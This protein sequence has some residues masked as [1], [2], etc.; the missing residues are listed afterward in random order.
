MKHFADLVARTLYRCVG[1]LGGG[2]VLL[3]LYVSLGRQLV[4]L[5]AE[6]RADAE[7]IVAR[8]LGVPVSIER[9]EGRWDG[10]LPRLLAH[11][12]FIGEGDNPLRLDRL[13]LVPD[14]AES[15]WTR[16]PYLSELRLAGL[17]LS[18]QQDDTGAWRVE[19]FSPHT[20]QAAADP[21]AILQGLRRVRNL[22]LIDSQLTLT[23]AGGQPQ[24]LSYANLALQSQGER[25]RLDGHLLLPD[26]KPLALQARLDVDGRQWQD[27][28]L[29]L[30]LDLPQSDWAALVPGHLPSDWRVRQLEM[31]GELW[32]RIR[33]RRLERGVARLQA[34][35]LELAQGE[36]SVAPLSE[37][38]VTVHAEQREA[39][40]HMQLDGLTFVQGE[41]HQGD[42]RLLLDQQR[43]TGHWRLRA[44]HVQLR[45]LAHLLREVMVLPEV[46]AEALDDLA[47][48]GLLRNLQLDYRPDRELAQRLSYSANLEAVSIREHGWVPAAGN[49]SGS[50]TGDLGSGE[51]RFDSRDFSL[52]LARLFPAAWH[53]R[54]SQGSLQ[55]H[56]D[57][58]AFT[59]RA[60]YLRLDGEEGQLA[61]DL[62]IRLMRDPEAEDYMD[63]RVGMSD[64]D[65]RFTERY[66][67]T[68]SPALTPA[69]VDWLKDAIRAGHVEQGYF[70]YQGSLNKGAPAVAH[71]LGLY[72]KV[73]DAEL[74]FQPGWP[75][76]REGRGEVLVENGR[77][78]VRLD[79]GRIL[80]SQVLQAQA[81]IAPAREGHT[82]RLALQGKVIGTLADGM[83]ILQEAPLGTGQV[84]AGWQAEG[85]LQAQLDLDI[86]LARG[87]QPQIRVDFSSRDAS[88]QLREP[89]LKLRALAGDF[90]YDS[91]KGLSATRVSAR[92]FG[93]DVSGRILATGRPGEPLSR[94]EVR[95][96]LAL[97]SLTRWLGVT[98]QLPARGEL[99]YQLR[100][101]I[102]GAAARLQ[103]DSSLQG[104]AIDLPEPFR[105]GASTRRDTSFHMTLQGEQRRY[106]FQHAALAAL[107][108]MAPA[109]RLQEGRGELR[110]GGGAA[111]LPGNQGLRVRG[112]LS[113]LDWNAW[114]AVL[115]NVQG[116]G[117]QGMPA[118]LSFLREA[119]L[120]LDRFEGFGT[121]ID[122]L[123]VDLRSI[124][125]AW[126]LGLRSQVVDGQVRL[127]SATGAPIDVRLR[128]LRL[129]AAKEADAQ[130]VSVDPL[131]G[132]DP[133][134]LPA[135]DLLIEQLFRGD[136][137]LGRWA[138]KLRP[139]AGGTAMSDIDLDL[140]GLKIG[141]EM[142]WKDGRTTYKGRLHGG[143]L[144]DVLLAWGFAPSTSSNSFHLDADGN[145]PGSPA[146]FALQRYSGTLAPQLRNG[147]FKEVE[148]S[149]QA[150][151]VFGLLNFNAIGR[152]LRLDFSDLFGKGLGY[153]RLKGTLQA[154]DGVFLTREPITVTSP[155]SNLEL[156]GRLDMVTD[157]IDAKL[158]VTLPVSNNLPLAALIVG[159]PAI[160]GAL[161]IADKL[162]GDRVARFA[163]VQYDVKG[164]WQS[165]QI[166][167][168]RPFEK[169]N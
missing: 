135:V 167:F 7:A 102:G 148:G 89:E 29:D 97:E 22:L 126:Q 78:R 48:S 114:Q 138:L 4:P 129:P 66:L 63:L 127:P 118:D 12:V 157:S 140:K 94:I 65:A 133:A 42:M 1:L 18:L 101:D 30:Y 38:G 24:T 119:R 166:T 3:A 147:Q 105:K 120:R 106:E 20:P 46:A 84:F 144:E 134:S 6:Y 163:T 83:H 159:A 142:T 67:P 47:P 52:H 69:L 10:L 116:E 27:S 92:A 82:P 156:N 37:L 54:R 146:W 62:L 109:G 155:S 90:R 165:P 75:A 43:A 61:G 17:H 107:V 70:Q 122:S 139:V 35:R 5:V 80:N 45:P 141:G 49:V 55:W 2:L 85:P 14:L 130:S 115:E 44:D 121:R 158:L 73:R 104:L 143:N 125:N 151:R 111:A 71:H 91:A 31:G 13:E 124:Q 58:Q 28:A 19:G 110:L 39:G 56:L 93:R 95:G 74:A 50:I 108:Y 137:L 152:R 68:L 168:D 154:S 87:A 100:V 98:Q 117:R 153:D 112:R 96:S 149:A 57:E 160:G 128:Y 64:A 41:E 59:L 131:A 88:L 86:P 77:V 9:L 11:D 169:P 132:I 81:E 32:L 15:L 51:L 26:G 8:Q 60:P 23:V 123:D 33:E 25:L 36:R 150:L 79:E 145:W 161:F 103:V 34:P 113:Q 164:A 72:F 53:Y 76:L 136:S 162:L 16:Q 21:Q 99:P 40:W